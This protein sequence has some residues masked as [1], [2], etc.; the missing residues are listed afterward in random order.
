MMRKV[1][2]KYLMKKLNNKKII[3]SYNV[4]NSGNLKY[5]Y[6]THWSSVSTELTQ[7][8]LFRGL[9]APIVYMQKRSYKIVVQK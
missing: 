9:K 3:R 1:K 8:A 7:T 4:I 2:K 5:L 6:S